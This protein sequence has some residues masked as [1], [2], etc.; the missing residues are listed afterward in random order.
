MGGGGGGLGSEV[1]G[2]TGQVRLPRVVQAVTWNGNDTKCQRCSESA[3]GQGDR[4]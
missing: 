3:R 2:E 4:T 1:G